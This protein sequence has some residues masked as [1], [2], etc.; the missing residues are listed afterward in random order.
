MML[1]QLVQEA[2]QF[3]QGSLERQRLLHQIVLA[4]Q[5]SGKIWRG[6]GT[7]SPEAYAE[8]LQQT[9]L[10]FCKHLDRYDPDKAGVI[11]WFNAHLRYR[12]LDVLRRQQTDQSVLVSAVGT[13]QVD[14]IR[15]LAAHPE[16][17]PLL[18]NV[19]QWIFHQREELWQIHLRG[20]PEVNCAVLLWRRLPPPTPWKALS[21]E[22]GVPVATLSNFYQQKCYPR[23]LAFGRYEGY[24]DSSS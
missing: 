17:P 4:M 5:R 15:Q 6:G 2:H 10:Y 21:R 19:Q 1:H 23:L 7:V 12:I 9:W 20:R 16:P 3:P 18:E 8:A 13:E 14:P 22:F 24:L 11:T